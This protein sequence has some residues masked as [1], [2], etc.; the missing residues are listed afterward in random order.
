MTEDELCELLSRGATEV[1]RFL[2]PL[3]EPARRAIAP[4]VAEL[5]RPSRSERLGYTLRGVLAVAQA[6]TLPAA[7]LTDSLRR[8][9]TGWHDGVGATG[10]P[11]ETQIGGW[12]VVATILDR[13]PPWLP[14][15]VE[16][17][18]EQVAWGGFEGIPVDVV[19]ALRCAGGSP[20]PTCAPYLT[21]VVAHIGRCPD[22]DLPQLLRDDE[23]LRGLL[24]A[25]LAT[26][27]VGTL[28]GHRNTFHERDEHGTYS[29]RTAPP[30]QTWPGA[31]ALL[32]AEGTIDRDHLLAA[33]LDALVRGGTRGHVGGVLGIHEALH[34]TTE[35]AVRHLRSYVGLVADGPGTTAG[36]AL[37]LLR[38]AHD[39]GEM[40]MDTALDVARAALS[41]PEKGLAT[42]TLTWLHRLNRSAP[43]RVN[44]V[45][46]AAAVALQH[47]RRDVQEKAL[48]ALA[49]LVPRCDLGTVAQLREAAGDVAPVLQQR[50]TQVLGAPDKPPAPDL[51]MPD[52]VPDPS[53]PGGLPFDVAVEA[54]LLAP[55]MDLRDLVEA[56]A[57]HVETR[58][59]R[60]GERVLDGLSR[61]AAADPEGVRKALWPL[62]RRLGY[63]S[64]PR[65]PAGFGWDSSERGPVERLLRD[66]MTPGGAPVQENDAV[67]VMGWVPPGGIDGCTGVRVLELAALIHGSV[68]GP[69]L[70]TPTRVTGAI[71]PGAALDRLR[72]WSQIGANPGPLDLQQLWLRLPLSADRDAL[73]QDLRAIGSPASQWLAGAVDYGQPDIEVVPATVRLRQHPWRTHPGESGLGDAPVADVLPPPV[74]NPHLIERAGTVTV[75]SRS[76]GH[77]TTLP[78]RVADAGHYWER[79]DLAR[80]LELLLT[81]PQHRDAVAAHLVIRL[82]ET[83]AVGVPGVTQTLPLL[84]LA[85]GPTGIGTALAIGW[86]AAAGNA[87]V[88]T[89]SADALRGFARAGGLDGAAAGL[90]IGELLAWPTVSPM[91]VARTLTEASRANPAAQR[92]VWDIVAAALPA[93]IVSGRR[94]LLDLLVLAV[95]LA[96]STGARGSVKGLSGVA[97][98][99][100]TRLATEARR[101][102]EVLNR[103]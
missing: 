73:A 39:A 3:D 63:E 38:E 65:R 67:G 83:T 102:E 64:A 69:L 30:E 18:A 25:I 55:V 58:D 22:L 75:W 10:G 84:P 51:V 95:D 82:L 89:A 14:D 87:E 29:T 37:R 101:L 85:G 78:G 91:R 54:D 92:L 15:L 19:E 81:L 17:L 61:H 26:N 40:D 43:D 5:T 56:A 31:L 98:G 90:S 24:P 97:S 72:A 20:R 62:R 99:G 88:A 45:A 16:R 47:E 93:A 36:V 4:A 59:P 23:E 48:D 6:G 21:G 46:L 7:A 103:A 80:P 2:A 27:D 11:R 44:E 86:A 96:L 1:R 70:S 49:K 94:G 60:A 77:A 66:V 52:L 68:S 34:P 53:T 28:M 9:D 33:A 8:S 71:D 76:G 50:V 35:D 32:S 13:R 41:R 79:E 74:V 57:E 42:A 100:R 12:L